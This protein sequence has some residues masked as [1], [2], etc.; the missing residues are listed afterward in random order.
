MDFVAVVAKFPDGMASFK[1]PARRLQARSSPQIVNGAEKL[2]ERV[3]PSVIG[4][5]RVPR[6]C[7]LNCLAC[8]K[9]MQPSK[10]F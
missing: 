9:I 10:I 8:S 5:E 3:R 1:V 7:N 4:Q 2:L 6:E